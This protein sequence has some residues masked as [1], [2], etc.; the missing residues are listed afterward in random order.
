M[1]TS[2]KKL[3]QMLK[4]LGPS[5]KL[6]RK[7]RLAL[8]PKIEN[9]LAEAKK[10]EEK[11][12]IA[13]KKELEIARKR[14]PKTVER[15][16]V[17]PDFYPAL[18]EERLIAM[19]KPVLLP[20]LVPRIYIDTVVFLNVFK[21]E[22]LYVKSSESVLRSVEF[23]CLRGL[24]SDYTKIEIS[25]ILKNKELCKAAFDQLNRWKVQIVGTT[26]RIKLNL[27]IVRRLMDDE[28][29]LIHAST[30][31]TEKVEVLTTRNIKD[32]IE[33]QRYFLVW[34][35]EKVVQQFNIDECVAKKKEKLVR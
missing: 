34:P 20:S 8:S 7:A 15:E 2:L 28:Y 21:K 27:L 12:V 18:S 11:R 3:H 4:R 24:T 16:H 6:V 35:P 9:L 31:L 30:A 23:G 14:K 17:E 29:D 22:P 1:S 10:L 25:L 5:E 32:F 26:D 13:L 19:R 33:L